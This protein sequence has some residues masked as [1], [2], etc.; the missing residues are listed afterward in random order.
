[1]P[2]PTTSA[3]QA[4]PKTPEARASQSGSN[5]AASVSKPGAPIVPPALEVPPPL[6]QRAGPAWLQD[7]IPASVSTTPSDTDLP[8]DD[9]RSSRSYLGLYM[10]A[11]AMVALI[12]VAVS[13][14]QLP[15]LR[16]AKADADAL[17]ERTAVEQRST[18]TPIGQPGASSGAAS[19]AET[20]PIQTGYP[21]A[22]SEKPGL[23]S[24][25]APGPRP[26]HQEPAPT[27]AGSQQPASTKRAPAISANSGAAPVAQSSG[28]Q[29]RKEP[30]GDA[31]TRANESSFRGMHAAA[32]EAHGSASVTSST[33]PGQM[34]AAPS[35]NSTAPRV[36]SAT[37][38][39]AADTQQ[40]RELQKQL[41]LL[42]ARGRTVQSAFEDL[43]KQQQAQG[44]SSRQDM[45]ASFER[46][47]QFLD[48]AHDA[49][50]EGKMDEANNNVDS[51]EREIAKLEKFLGR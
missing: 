47:K 20:G 37:G 13:A 28:V 12:V 16:K 18:D 9:N 36:T 38:T 48:G 22:D 46:L 33:A 14:T 3:A 24:S 43:P 11:G 29:Q 34:S 45:T 35:A 17:Q 26:E 10:T 21:V 7:P 6:T 8:V 51:A 41:T 15:R 2:P 19:L 42:A 23:L 39:G 4:P 5:E 27:N 1:M 31:S 50:T 30:N 32:H 40:A 25:S 44:L 49:L